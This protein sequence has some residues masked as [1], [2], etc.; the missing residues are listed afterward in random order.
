MKILTISL[1]VFQIVDIK[2]LRYILLIS[3]NRTYD[4]NG[5]DTVFTE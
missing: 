3:S 1:D 2:T 4:R 5:Y